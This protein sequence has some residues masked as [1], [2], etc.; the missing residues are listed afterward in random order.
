[1]IESIIGFYRRAE[2]VP[3]RDQED[4]DTAREIRRRKWSVF[5]T[6]TFGYGFYY[7]CRLSF[8]VAKKPMAEA[9]VFNAAELGIIGSALF[10]AYAFGKLCNG[11]LADHVNVRAFM[12]TGLFVSALVNLAL[13]F[14]TA[15]WLFFVLWGI[16]G[17]FQSFGAPSSVVSLANWYDDKERGTIY[18]FWSSSHNIGEAVTFIGTAV[19]VSAFGWKWGFRAA[20]IACIV[21][22]IVVW[23]F[24]CERPSTYGLQ[25][26]NHHKPIE[27][28]SVSV[29][30][31]QLAVLK[32]RAVWIL[33]LSSAF[34][35][36]TRYAVNSWGIFFLEA[37]KGYTTI[38]ASSI[39]S[40]NAVAGIFGTLLSGLA[41]DRFFS[42]RRNVPAL[43]FGL[44]YAAAISLFVLGP[45]DPVSDTVSM[46]LFG[47]S[48]GVL[49]VY[50]GGLM[51]VDI[52]SK[53]AAG[54]ALGIVGVASYLGAAIQD[55]VSGSLIEN[56]KAYAG[57]EV[58]YNFNSVAV[59][60]IGAALVS[61][62]LA[63]LVWRSGNT[64]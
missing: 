57:T 25:I 52:A 16:N 46:V 53:E 43:I 48:V 31:M 55:V 56:G 20:G 51:A 12:T 34:F 64:G 60:W 13:G 27:R 22:S 62:G 40:V 2:S 50:L 39:V 35:Y 11:I 26:R 24:L 18:G 23:R 61:T 10:F 3:L 54:T 1:M 14:T 7:I 44:L 32:N 15:S 45:A 33:A 42:G 47:L 30:S 49:L 58:I 36:V 6:I 21:M 9:G 38:E 37:E 59:L 8:S 4:P 41:S 17:W 19:V 5:L 63:A 29:G 28:E